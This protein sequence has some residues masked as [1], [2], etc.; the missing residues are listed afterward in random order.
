MMSR[1]RLFSAISAGFQARYSGGAKD[2]LEELSGLIV[3][4]RRL[5]GERGGTERWLYPKAVAPESPSVHLSVRVPWRDAGW[6]G[7]VC[8][9]PRE[10]ASCLALNRIG[11]TKNEAIEERYAGKRLSDVPDAEMPPCIAERVNFLSSRPQ[12]RLAHHAYSKTS[13]HHKHICDTPFA[14]PAFSA[15]A[16]PFGWLLKERAWGKEWKKGKIDNQSMVERCGIDALPEY[17]PEEPDWLHDRPWIQG[18]ANQKALLNAFFGALQPQR[19]LIFVYAKRAP[20]IGDDQWMIIGVGRVTSVGEL[21][22]W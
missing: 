4:T 2:D 9:A 18:H 5:V 12:R 20:L 13:E 10:N 14:H 21:Q 8:R 17:E 7:T 3:R 19:S 15:A 11:A 6:D 22:E 16:T 1:K